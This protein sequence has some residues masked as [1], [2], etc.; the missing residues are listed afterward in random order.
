MHYIIQSGE[1]DV[2]K[3]TQTVFFT[4]VNPMFAHLHKQRDSDV[5]KPRIAVYKPNFENTSEYSVVGQFESCLEEG[6]DVPPNKFWREHPSQH[7]P[8]SVYWDSGGNE[9]RRS[10][11]K[12]TNLLAHREKLYKNR[13]GKKDER[14]R[15]IRTR[16]NSE[17]IP[18]STGR[19]VAWSARMVRRIHRKPC[20]QKSSRTQGRTLELL[21]WVSFRAAEKK[22]NRVSTVFTITSRRTDIATFAWRPR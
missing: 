6:I 19:R 10:S 8:S 3:G 12:Y 16:D 7:S 1:K 13:L 21:S 2:K 15:Q 9:F 22:W 18:A 5:T 4:T 11:V 14:I 20:G 17:S